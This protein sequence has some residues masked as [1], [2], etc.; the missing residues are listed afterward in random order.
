MILKIAEIR[1]STA[2]KFIWHYKASQ[3]TTFTVIHTDE[4]INISNYP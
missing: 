1:N 2:L 3:L 4:L